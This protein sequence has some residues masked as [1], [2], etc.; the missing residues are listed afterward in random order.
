[1]HDRNADIARMTSQLRFWDAKL[2]KLE[3]A[4]AQNGT[5]LNADQQQQIEELRITKQAIQEELDKAQ[6]A[7]NE[8]LSEEQSICCA[9]GD[10]S[11][12]CRITEDDA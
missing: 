7:G 12:A 8:S 2:R 3:A 1:M 10:L 4:A 11:G 5:D 9:P 6:N